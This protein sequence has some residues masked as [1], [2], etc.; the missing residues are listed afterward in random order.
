MKYF[1]FLLFFLVFAPISIGKKFSL[2]IINTPIY[3]SIPICPF[4]SVVLLQNNNFENLNINKNE[5]FVIDFSPMEDI[6]SRNVILKLLQG[7]TIQGKVRVFRFSTELCK[8]I[9]RE[10]LTNNLYS[11]KSFYESSEIQVTNENIK[12][13]ENIDPYLV[14]IIKSW[15][16]SFQIYNRNCRNFS[17][18]LQRNYL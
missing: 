9:F 6:S 15:D 12:K 13:L 2:K 16:S 5:G 4:H 18:F 10:P 17:D 7:K 1:L 3:S 14:F 11:K 8:T